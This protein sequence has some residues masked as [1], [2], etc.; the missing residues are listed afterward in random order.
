MDIDTEQEMDVIFREIIK[1]LDHIPA[2]M[3][4][5]KSSDNQ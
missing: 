4:G 5:A 2:S 3:E 1:Q